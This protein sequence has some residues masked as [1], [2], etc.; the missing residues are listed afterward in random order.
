MKKVLFLIVASLSL[1]TFLIIGLPGVRCGS[2][3]TP[4]ATVSIQGDVNGDGVVDMGDVT[5]VERIILGKDPYTPAADVNQDGVVN[6]ADVV[7]IENII[8]GRP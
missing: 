7:A 2:L 3:D 8:L 6:M 5:K 4:T 1:I